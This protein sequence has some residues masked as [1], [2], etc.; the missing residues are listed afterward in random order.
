MGRCFK[1]RVFQGGESNHFCQTLMIGQVRLVRG[2]PLTKEKLLVI[3]TG[4]MS[5]DG[6]DRSP[7]GVS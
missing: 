1:E 6:G 7:T 3:L 5:V 4:E 2:R